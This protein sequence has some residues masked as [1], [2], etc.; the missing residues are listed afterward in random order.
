MQGDERRMTMY[1]PARFH[2]ENEQDNKITKGSQSEYPRQ[3]DIDCPDCMPIC[4]SARDV[5]VPNG[6][7]QNENG[8]IQIERHLEEPIRESK[9]H[10]KTV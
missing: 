4:S 7:E 8:S 9:R 2:L 1:L 6:G 10:P 5:D 3:G